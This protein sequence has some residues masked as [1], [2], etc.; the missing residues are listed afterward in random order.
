MNK[1]IEV[2]KFYFVHDG[3]KT[4]HPCLIIWK[5]DKA[6]RYLVVRF[7]SDKRGDIPKTDRGIRHITKL[8][9]CTDENVV[10]SYIRNR[11]MLCKRKDFGSIDLSHMKI[12][13]DDFD[14][15]DAVSKK[16][17]EFSQSFKKK[18]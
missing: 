11:P 10:A 18:K 13:P 16:E 1:L 7:D 8:K 14:K 4:G 3:S 12:H 15:I 5:D 6:N 2:G 9:H 17:P